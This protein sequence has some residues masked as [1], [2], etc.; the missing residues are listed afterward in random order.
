MASYYYLLGAVLEMESGASG[1]WFLSDIVREAVMGISLPALLLF[2]FAYE[3][4][5][6][7]VTLTGLELTEL[8][9]LLPP[10][11]WV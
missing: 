8:F 1:G 11:S 2:Y 6:H 7:Y 9:M 5:S 10:E 4:G 3:T